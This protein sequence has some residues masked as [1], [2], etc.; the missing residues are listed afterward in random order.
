MLGRERT[1]P[2][3]VIPETSD[4]TGSILTFMR[5]HQ[6][7]LVP[8]DCIFPKQTVKQVRVL[9]S[10][11][12]RAC[13][14]PLIETS[15]QKQPGSPYGKV[16]A[17]PYIPRQCPSLKRHLLLTIANGD[18]EFARIDGLEW[19]DASRDGIRYQDS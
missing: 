9:S 15:N 1:N 17:A 18:G 2:V 11:A 19:L 7:G 13:P 4:Q 12:G 6:F 5:D 8:Y 10:F 14:K 16:S 3:T